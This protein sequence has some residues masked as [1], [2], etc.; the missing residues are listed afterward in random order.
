MD[1][2]SDP[3]DGF[4]LDGLPLNPESDFCEDCG[5]EITDDNKL[6]FCSGCGASGCQTCLKECN[7]VY[8]CRDKYDKKMYKQKCLDL[9]WA[10]FRG[11]RDDVVEKIH[12]F[13]N[14]KD[15]K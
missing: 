7:D 14:G 13:I 5:E 9:I 4:G 15:K 10:E 12:K 11:V 2:N 8:C 3:L 6:T 1:Y